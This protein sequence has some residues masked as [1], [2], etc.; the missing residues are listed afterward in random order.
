MTDNTEKD[1]FLVTKEVSVS[2]RRPDPQGGP[3]GG[4]T[5]KMTCDVRS[6]GISHYTCC[7]CGTN[8]KTD[9]GSTFQGSNF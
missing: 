7:N 8:W 6:P 5:A 2:C 9:T 3:C 4:F 1:R